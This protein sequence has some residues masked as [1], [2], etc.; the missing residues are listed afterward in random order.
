M[1]IKLKNC[2]NESQVF[3]AEEITHQSTKIYAPAKLWVIVS[4]AICS[5]PT[6]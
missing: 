4:E 1:K 2:S 5:N 6:K 3:S